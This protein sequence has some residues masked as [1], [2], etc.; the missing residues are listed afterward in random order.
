LKLKKYGTTLSLTFTRR[1]LFVTALLIKT[2]QFS[3]NPFCLQQSN[4]NSQLTLSYAF[5]K[6]NLRTTPYCF[7]NLA[8]LRTSCYNITL[9][10]MYLHLIKAVWQGWIIL[11]IPGM[12]VIVK[13]FVKILNNTWGDK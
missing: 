1:V 13:V 12:T 2:N 7:L 8:S 6:S 3:L 10:V 11:S 4:K 5:W 9:S